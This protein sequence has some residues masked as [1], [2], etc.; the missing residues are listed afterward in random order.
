MKVTYGLL[1]HQSLKQ[2]YAFRRNFL[3]LSH[4][5]SNSYE[6]KYKKAAEQTK[7]TKEKFK[8]Q[9]N[10]TIKILF[11]LFILHHKPLFFP[12][13]LLLL[14]SSSPPLLPSF[15]STAFCLLLLSL[16]L[17]LLLHLL[18]LL[19]HLLLLRNNFYGK[20]LWCDHHQHSSLYQS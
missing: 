17:L 1:E 7:A 10:K 12:L 20:H 18:L 13:L 5:D 3:G 4:R 8:T 2:T 11:L 16:L 19:L 15:S 14:L 6:Q 9:N